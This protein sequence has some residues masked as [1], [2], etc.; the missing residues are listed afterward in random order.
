M[1]IVFQIDQFDFRYILSFHARTS[2]AA[3]VLDFYGVER[4]SG[5]KH[6]VSMLEIRLD[7]EYE[8]RMVAAFLKHK[9]FEGHNPE[10]LTTLINKDVAPITIEESLLNAAQLGHAEVLKSQ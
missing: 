7:E 1:T 10:K 2:M 8:N 6:G 3:E 9:I 5:S 4:S